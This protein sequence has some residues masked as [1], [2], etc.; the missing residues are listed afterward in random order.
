MKIYMRHIRQAG[1]CAKGARE[2][3]NHYQFDF[4]DFLKNGI[5]IKLIENTQDSMALKVVEIAKQEQNNG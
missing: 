3:F 2:F 1:L 4:N 5:D